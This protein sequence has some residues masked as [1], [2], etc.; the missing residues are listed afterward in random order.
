MAEIKEVLEVVDAVEAIAVGIGHASEGGLDLGEV[1]GVLATNISK[2]QTAITGAEDIPA[3]LDDLDLDEVEQLTDRLQD[4][5]F[6]IIRSFGT[7]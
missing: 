5:V 1:L 3:E 6:N 7:P 2:L 4:A